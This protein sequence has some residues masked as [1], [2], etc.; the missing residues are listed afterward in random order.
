MRHGGVFELH[1]DGIDGDVGGGSDVEQ[2]DGGDDDGAIDHWSQR[3]GT[4]YVIEK[5]VD[6]G[7][8]YSN[9]VQTVPSAGVRIVTTS[10]SAPFS[11]NISLVNSS[12]IEGQWVVSAGATRYTLAAS[13]NEQL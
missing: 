7:V 9:P 4:T 12:E 10:I 5:S 13:T 6:G 8:T 1:G 11:G 2:W 3:A